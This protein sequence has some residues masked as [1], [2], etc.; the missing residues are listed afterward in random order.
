MTENSDAPS[1]NP[2][3]G[4]VPA[5]GI[6]RPGSRDRWLFDNAR[7][8]IIYWDDRGSVLAANPAAARILGVDALSMPGQSGG[9]PPWR[10]VDRDG[11]EVL[12]EEAPARL[13]FQ[14][15]EPVENVVLGIVGPADRRTVWIEVSA[16]PLLQDDEFQDACVCT[17]FTDITERKSLEDVRTFL[18]RA[19]WLAR[20][21]DFFRA[22][23]RFLASH[24]EMDYVC[25]D[26]LEGDAL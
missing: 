17:T 8:G 13:A 12:P 15:G 20:G 5:V 19:E 2:T 7:H 24:L 21:E 4:P 1:S 9:A 3:A 18:A 10:V 22:L 26:R 11:A 25:I 6:A 23:A 14:R 16:I